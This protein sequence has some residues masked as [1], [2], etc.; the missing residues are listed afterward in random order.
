LRGTA[1]AAITAIA[2]TLRAAVDSICRLPQTCKVSSDI[3]F[4][5]GLWRLAWFFKGR[6]SAV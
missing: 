4:L 5:I 3:S 2:A 6:P 1:V